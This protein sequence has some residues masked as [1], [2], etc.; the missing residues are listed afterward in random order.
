[1]KPKIVLTHWAHPETIELL[2]SVAEVVPNLT[3]D[4]LP[5][6]EILDRA[7]DAQGIMVFMPDSIDDAFLAACPELRVVGAALKGYDNFDVQACTRRGIWFTIVPDLLT[8]PTA[9]LTIGLLLGITRH[10]LPGDRYI[11][12]GQYKGWVPDFYGSGLTDKTLGIIGMGAVGRAIAKRLASFDINVLYTDKTALP[13]DLESAYNAR[14]VDLDELLSSSDYVVPM[15]PM[16]AETFHTI[17]KNTLAQ[18]KSGSYLINT[19][20]GSVADEL[21]VVEALRTGHLA[22]YAADV[23]E[24]EEWTRQDR[25]QSIPAALLDPTLPTLFTPHLGSD[26]KSVRMKIER[27]A[28]TNILQALEG[29]RPQGAVNDVLGARSTD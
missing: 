29:F 15:L 7:K 5:R 23:Y 25:P 6:A 28:A 17:N 11:R 9:E 8:I 13:A 14:K 20:R 27:E 10:V 24:M 2:E 16:T 26:V 21:A 1:L 19:C 22:G 12:S 4:T 3:K 18:M